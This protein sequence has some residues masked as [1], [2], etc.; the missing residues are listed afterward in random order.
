MT[1]I[2]DRADFDERLEVLLLAADLCVRHRLVGDVDH[3]A[4]NACGAAVP[5]L[6]DPGVVAHPDRSPVRGDDPVFHRPP[7]VAAGEGGRLL[8]RSWRSR[9]SGWGTAAKNAGSIHASRG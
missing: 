7:V 4:L 8:R 1:T 6:H 2:G 9:S 5:V 3:H